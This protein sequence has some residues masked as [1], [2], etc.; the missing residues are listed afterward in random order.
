MTYCLLAAAPWVLWIC[1]VHQNDPQSIL[2]LLIM[3]LWHHVTVMWYKMAPNKEV[4]IDKVRQKI[5]ACIRV[6][7]WKSWQHI[8]ALGSNFEPNQQ[9]SASSGCG[10]VTWNGQFPEAVALGMGNQQASELSLQIADMNHN[11]P[12]FSLDAHLLGYAAKTATNSDRLC[13]SATFS[14][15]SGQ[16][17]TFQCF[18][19][20]GY[21]AMKR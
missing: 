4:S 19:P 9:L 6:K 1:T 17:M 20:Q 12:I 18:Q 3:V 10:R 15:P 2:N 7:V 21:D 11:I 5:Q 14:R 8:F 16:W 13:N